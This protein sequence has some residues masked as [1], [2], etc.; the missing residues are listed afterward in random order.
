MEHKFQVH[1]SEQ[2]KKDDEKQKI[3]EKQELNQIL[4][5]FDQSVHCLHSYPVYMPFLP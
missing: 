2:G 3:T 4:L 5:E 1:I